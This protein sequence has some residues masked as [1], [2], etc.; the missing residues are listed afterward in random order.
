MKGSDR[1]VLVILPAVA[2]LAAIW[3]LGISP[4]RAELSELDAQISAAQAQVAEQEQV[5]DFAAQARKKFPSSYRKIINLGKAA[6]SD[7]DTASLLVQLQGLADKSNV[8]FRTIT[9]GGDVGEA[10]EL[11]PAP[12]PPAAESAA[13]EAPPAE[14]PATPVA[15][16]EAS[17]SSLPIGAQI[18]PAGLPVMPYELVFAG[19]FFEISDFLEGVDAQVDTH[20]ASISV[21]GRLITVNGFTLKRD[22]D[23]GFPH[24]LASFSVAT[25]IVPESEGPTAGASP[26]GPAPTPVATPT[27]GSTP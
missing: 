19:D 4:K 7:S 20:K 22:Q 26:S 5:A 16:S 3:F 10:P 27:P 15:A 21:D 11:P 13:P 24:L 9:L 12:E 18:G 2:V 17:A 14:A 6:P 23:K 8:D 1:N 25:F